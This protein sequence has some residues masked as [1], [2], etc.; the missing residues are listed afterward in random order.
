MPS[1]HLGE[2]TVG[3]DDEGAGDALLLVHGHPFDRS[4]WRPQADRFSAEG[5]RV[6]VP[7]L[8]GYGESTV[9]PG[10]TAF[11]TFAGDLAGLLDALGLDDVVLGGVSMGGQLA[12]EFYRLYPERVRALVLSDTSPRAETEDG[13][14][15]R[16]RIADRLLREGMSPW[17]EEVLH[18]MVGPRTRAERPEVADH[19]LRMMRATSP[20]GAAAALRGRAERPDYRDLVSRVGVPSLVVVGTDDDYTPV[21]EAEALHRLM[22]GSV[23]AVVDGAGHLP[24]LELPEEFNAV[25]AEFLR[26]LRRSAG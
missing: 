19:V 18:R 5:W 13:R 15:D 11:E 2:V 23:L 16:N 1:A 24:N 25:L 17:A 20:E 8:R 14:I 10:L 6:V 26:P 22:P 7:D 4:M 9:V 3:Y 12:M 21:D